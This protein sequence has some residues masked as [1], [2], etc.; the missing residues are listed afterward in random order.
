MKWKKRA[1]DAIPIVPN[2]EA[3][4]KRA[5]ELSSKELD[6]LSERVERVERLAGSLHGQNVSNHYIERLKLSYGR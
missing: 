3:D 4:R 5:I 6:Q 2:D 1:T